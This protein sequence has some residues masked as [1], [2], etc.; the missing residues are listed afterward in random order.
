MGPVPHP[1]NFLHLP[2]KVF[3]TSRSKGS[4]RFIWKEYHI[5]SYKYKTLNKQS[6]II[7]IIF[8]FIF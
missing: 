3:V 8:F 6:G 1:R 7:K 5:K 2:F 4:Y